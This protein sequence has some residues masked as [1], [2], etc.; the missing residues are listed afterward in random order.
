[1]IRLT[2]ARYYTPSG[3]LIQKS[4]KNGVDNY[5][6][7]LIE[8]YKHGE[9]VSADSIH[10]P[11]SLKF[12][13]RMNHR[14][15]YGGGGIMP[16][17]FVPVDTSANY[18][19]SNS[20]VRSGV[21]T[22]FVLDYLDEHRDQLKKEYNS[23]DDFKTGFQVDD[24]I[25]DALNKMAFDEGVK[26]EAEEVENSAKHLRLIVKALIARDTWNISEYYEIVNENDD[27]FAKA[28]EVLQDKNV[29][30]RKL[31]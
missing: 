26:S 7:D 29:Y 10:F 18:S 1:M 16:D 12:Y 13:T 15:V 11:D 27:S 28:V 5:M 14:P 25:L 21:L 8:R 31:K 9:L 30:N 23:F 3:R 4:Y 17:I 22:S 6:K 20:L 2:I 19:Y 24:S